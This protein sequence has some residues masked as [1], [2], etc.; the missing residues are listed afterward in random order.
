MCNCMKKY[1]VKRTP[2]F[3]EKKSLNKKKIPIKKRF[4]K[5]NKLFNVFIKNL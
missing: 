4:V 3:L 5:N 2:F 1:V